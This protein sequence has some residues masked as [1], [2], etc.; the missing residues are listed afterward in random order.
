[1]GQGGVL[2]E[3]I[4]TENGYDEQYMIMARPQDSIGWQRLMEGMV[5]ND[6][7]HIQ[8]THSLKISGLRCNT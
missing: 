3:E 6:I 1:M 7:W 5:C 2:M 4:C 8:K